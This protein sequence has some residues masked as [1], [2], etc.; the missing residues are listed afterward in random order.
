MAAGEKLGREEGEVVFDWE[1]GRLCVKMSNA[2]HLHAAGCDTEGRVLEC[3]ESIDV[4]GFEVGEPDGISV[5]DEGADEG[6]KGDEEGL[7]LLAPTG[8]SKGAEDVSAGGGT[9]DDG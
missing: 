2:G 5:G 6:F 8:A 3:L 1:D 4:G 9:F 7:L